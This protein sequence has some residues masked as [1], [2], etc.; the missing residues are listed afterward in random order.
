MCACV[1]VALVTWRGSVCACVLVALVVFFKLPPPPLLSRTFLLILFQLIF[2]VLHLALVSPFPPVPSLCP[3][4]PQLS[5]SF[6]YVPL[7]PA[8]R[9]CQGLPPPSPFDIRLSGWYLDLEL[10]F[11]C[12]S[13]SG[14]PSR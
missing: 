12:V 7:F 14:F 2:F 6:L 8:G 13:P 11:T 9:L 4:C 1:L 5:N 3:S 10:P